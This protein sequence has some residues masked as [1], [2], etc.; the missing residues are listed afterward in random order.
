MELHSIFFSTFV[1]KKQGTV[2][3]VSLPVQHN[4]EAAGSTSGLGSSSCDPEMQKTGQ[5]TTLCF[6]D[7]KTQRN[8]TKNTFIDSLQ[9]SYHAPQSHPSYLPFALAAPNSLSP[10][11]KKKKQHTNK[12]KH[13]K[14]FI[15]EAL[16]CHSVSH[17]APLC[18]HI[19]TCK[20][21]LQ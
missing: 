13:R 1:Y 4:Q 21:L 7:K 19:F 20:C 9:V 16:P 6:L 17:S 15:M 11:M 5:G 2:R 3:G 14:Y 12:I 18:P 8:K 10:K